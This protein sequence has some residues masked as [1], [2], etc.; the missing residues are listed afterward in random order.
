MRIMER[1]IREAV[2]A[3]VLLIALVPTALGE[4]PAAPRG[5][6]YVVLVD[7][8]GTMSR[9]GRGDATVTVLKT[10]IAGLLPGDRIT[11]YSYGEGARAVLSTYPAST[12]SEAARKRIARE[13]SFSFDADRTDMTAGMELVWSE[14]DRVF[15][16][17]LGKGGPGA[18]GVIV[19]L[20]DGK[21]IPVYDD[22]ARYDEIY[23]EK[24]TRLRQLASL[25]GQEGI[26]V[27]TVGLGHE[28]KLDG[29]LLAELA[30][31][32]GGDYYHSPTASDLQGVFT[33]VLTG[34]LGV[35]PSKRAELT[36]APPLTET[37]AAAES[38]P[39]E[40][41]T[42][43]AG[44]EPTE[45]AAESGRAAE[46]TETGH[47]LPTAE[48]ASLCDY[49]LLLDDG[50]S[51]RTAGFAGPI[52]D[53]C[54]MIVDLA[55]PGDF[56]SAYSCGESCEPLLD[57]TTVELGALADRQR[58]R[59]DLSMRFRASRSDLALALELVWSDR[60]KLFPGAVRAACGH[61]AVFILT[62]GTEP[63]DSAESQATERSRVF[64][65]ASELASSGVSVH[66]LALG[67]V[68]AHDESLLREAAHVT[69]GTYAPVSGAAGLGDALLDA[70]AAAGG[71]VPLSQDP[72]EAFVVDEAVSSLSVVSAGGSGRLT[73][74][75]PDGSLVTQASS[76]GGAVWSSG[77][78]YA[79]AV[80]DSPP[81][82]HWKASRAVRVAVESDLVPLAEIP[83]SWH[84]SGRGVVIRA[85]VE[86]DPGAYRSRDEHL[87]VDVLY[88][89]DDAWRV[90]EWRTRLSLRDDGRGVDAHMGDGIFSCE[91]PLT[92]PGTFRLAVTISGMSGRYPFTRVVGPRDITVLEP[93]FTFAAPGEGKLSER[94]RPQL[95]FSAA[96]TPSC[97]PLSELSMTATV[98]GPDGSV[99]AYALDQSGEGGQ[100]DVSGFEIPGKYS[101]SYHILGTRSDGA[102]V[103]VQ[104]DTY[105]HDLV[106]VDGFFPSRLYQASTG[107]LA[108]L[109][110]IVAVGMGR[111]QSWTAFFTKPLGRE[112]PKVRGYLKPFYPNGSVR[113]ARAI[114]GLENTGLPSV[115][116]GS[117][118][119][120]A[121]FARNTIIEFIGTGNGAPPTLRVEAGSVKVGGE[122]VTEPLV[123]HDGDVIE[124][125]GVS[126][127]YLRGSRS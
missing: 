17:S 116:I 58:L 62:D 8:T 96:K 93:W 126:Y 89:G 54:R 15:S 76:A 27:F 72:V 11:V 122:D 118:T 16:E 24:R 87:S 9:A 74:V 42:G 75:A 73:I 22:Y 81:S 95:T 84:Q 97:P 109:L 91:V 26:R 98:V 33:E 68:S 94:T 1:A 7:N 56:V 106:R 35:D 29:E 117:G 121:G 112:E 82:G 79:V 20:T 49:V 37:A 63:P 21:L 18:R 61:G 66:V 5:M 10:M 40:G 59:S 6:E 103:H 50:R 70:V 4:S 45:A 83:T 3:A 102:R 51:I 43:D 120:F 80:I 78:G 57:G 30:R 119:E 64:A 69:G 111:K 86:Q 46:R 23:K 88:A 107:V 123:L 31:R 77:E 92:D 39:I 53:G 28:S 110:G 100:T 25:F 113:T 36:L 115:T 104:S 114:I 101:V 38:G 65:A 127:T 44:R 71:F 2:L 125:E 90:P 60:E 41:Q 48:R 34:T 12:D 32:G 108:L 55:T 19:L 13:V 105:Q 85:W 52:I 99:T 67:A 47:L 124:I 14:R